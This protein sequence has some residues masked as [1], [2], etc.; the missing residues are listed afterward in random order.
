[1]P[2]YLSRPAGATYIVRNFQE[3]LNPTRYDYGTFSTDSQEE[4]KFLG[5]TTHKC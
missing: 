1:M 3:S 2:H 4:R 5:S